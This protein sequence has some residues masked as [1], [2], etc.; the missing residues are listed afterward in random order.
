MGVVELKAT[1]RAK[2]TTGRDGSTIPLM[3]SY[4]SRHTC[5][6]TRW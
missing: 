4:S 6:A 3:A 1:V 2:V 5:R